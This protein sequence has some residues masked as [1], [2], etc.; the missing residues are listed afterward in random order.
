MRGQGIGDRVE[1][2]AWGLVGMAVLRGGGRGVGRSVRRGGADIRAERVADAK[3]TCAAAC[4]TISQ[5]VPHPALRA[6]LSHKGRGDGGRVQESSNRKEVL[7]F[8][9]CCSIVPHEA[10][11]SGGTGM[12]SRPPLAGEGPGLFP[13]LALAPSARAGKRLTGFAAGPDTIFASRGT[14][15]SWRGRARNGAHSHDRHRRLCGALS[16][17]GPASAR[18]A[19][20]FL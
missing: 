9:Y 12:R 7:Y 15:A 16:A 18:Q 13:L 5:A 4:G 2:G 14:R 8:R 17:A 1:V 20:P 6:P 10:P 3:R 19:R 11:C